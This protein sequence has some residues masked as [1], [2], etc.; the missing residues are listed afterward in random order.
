M[1]RAYEELVDSIAA[2]MTSAEVARF[3]ASQATKEMVERLVAKEKASGLT[4]DEASELA[5]YLR[6]EHVTRLAKARAQERLDD[7]LRQR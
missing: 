7:Q 2:G 3:Q 5:N 6:L 1:I 4:S